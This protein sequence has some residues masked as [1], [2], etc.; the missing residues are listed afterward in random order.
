MEAHEKVK[1]LLV[2]L[3]NLKISEGLDTN[4]YAV[5]KEKNPEILKAFQNFAAVDLAITTI[6]EEI[7][8]DLNRVD[9]EQLKSEGLDVRYSQL[10]LMTTLREHVNFISEFNY[11]NVNTIDHEVFAQ[12]TKEVEEAFTAFT[13]TTKDDSKV[14]EQLTNLTIA[15]Y[16]G[17][18]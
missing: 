7:A 16:L 11:Q 3:I 6:I 2:A 15:V 1:E 10:V 13:E 4:D 14:K 17:V 12:K 9:L 8:N 18:M 5:L